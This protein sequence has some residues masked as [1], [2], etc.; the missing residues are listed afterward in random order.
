MTRMLA[1]M[2][3]KINACTWGINMNLTSVPFLKL[4]GKFN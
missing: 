3:V 1:H 2:P 4:E